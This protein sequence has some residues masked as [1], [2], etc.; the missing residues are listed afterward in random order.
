M[1]MF[2]SGVFQLQ[3]KLVLFCKGN[4]FFYNYKTGRDRDVYGF[5]SLLMK[6]A[7]VQRLCYR[8]GKSSV[9]PV[10]ELSL[11]F[12]RILKCWPQKVTLTSGVLFG[13]YKVNND[14]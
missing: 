14:P 12:C 5:F 13:K 10:A 8:Q 1:W 2:H 3:I 4:Q 11:I 6:M 9:L 7:A